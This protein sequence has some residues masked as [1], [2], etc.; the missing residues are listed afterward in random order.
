[1]GRLSSL[2]EFRLQS[3]DSAAIDPEIRVAD[4]RRRADVNGIALSIE[5]ELQVVDEA[6]EAALA[7]R[8]KIGRA[9]FDDRAPVRFLENGSQGVQVGGFGILDRCDELIL[10]RSQA[11]D[12]VGAAR[13]GPELGSILLTI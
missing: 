4:S 9:G 6:E 2:A 7:F 13:A 10:S 11:A 8:A 12:A 5:E 3:F 1:M